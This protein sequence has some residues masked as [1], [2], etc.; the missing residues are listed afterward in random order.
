MSN[1][2]LDRSRAQTE[3]MRRSNDRLRAKI[4]EIRRSNKKRLI[5]MFKED[6]EEVNSL[7][8]RAQNLDDLRF[9][10][11]RMKFCGQYIEIAYTLAQLHLID[12]TDSDEL[13]SYKEKYDQ[14]KKR[15]DS[16]Y[17]YRNQE[18]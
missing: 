5:E 17:E 4:E 12:S 15:I 16:Y 2:T 13:S 6:F 1:E 14:I 8:L 9:S 3:E 7:I 18:A 10:D 11:L